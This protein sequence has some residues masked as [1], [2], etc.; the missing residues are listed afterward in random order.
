V[1]VIHFSDRRKHLAKQNTLCLRSREE[2]GDT[3]ICME[4]SEH[5]HSK[6]NDVL[7]VPVSVKKCFIL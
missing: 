6:L 5:I 4:S 3:L 7:M 1:V 2:K